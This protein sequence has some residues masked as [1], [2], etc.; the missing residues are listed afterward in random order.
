MPIKE[1]ENFKT[2]R[3][4]E[5]NTK[6]RKFNNRRY[7]W[8]KWKYINICMYEDKILGIIEEK[9]WE[10][11]LN[12]TKDDKYYLRINYKLEH[13]LEGEEVVN[14][15]EEWSAWSMNEGLVRL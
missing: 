3:G 15:I 7:I 6:K 5:K 9:N 2:I 12:S 14:K 4:W 11:Y 13:E 10:P 8:K 1:Q